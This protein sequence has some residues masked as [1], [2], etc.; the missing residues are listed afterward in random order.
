MGERGGCGPISPQ[1]AL[2]L[3]PPSDAVRYS[4]SEENGAD[5]PM[6]GV[7][8][9]IGD[10]DDSDAWSMVSSRRINDSGPVSGKP[11]VLFIADT[12]LARM[13]AVTADRTMCFP[14][15]VCTKRKCIRIRPC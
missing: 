12:Q 6:M 3:R 13:P 2:S 4:S 10:V 14:S 8:G 1:S 5:R 9:V 15:Q 11:A 7:T